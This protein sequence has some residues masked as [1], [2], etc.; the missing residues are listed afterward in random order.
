MIGNKA[1]ITN[2]E[3]VSLF[4]LVVAMG[5]FIIMI[6]AVTSI[7]QLVIN[8]QRNATASLNT[9]ESMRYV[10]EILSKEIRSAQASDGSCFGGSPAVG[11]V[12]A[13]STNMLDGS[14]ILKYK[15]QNNE[16]V[17]LYLNAGTLM[18]S[19]GGS[20]A[21]TTPNRVA[22]SGLF[23]DVVDSPASQPKVTM[24]VKIESLGKE[25]HRLPMIIQTTLSSRNYE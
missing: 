20:A 16:C 24:R 5:I 21:S 23:F 11:R 13:T 6:L 18:I 10:M 17:S 22:A 7:F 19:R 14:D 3:G 15:N 2:Q 1:R 12:Y 25:M 8:A 9:Q 4:E